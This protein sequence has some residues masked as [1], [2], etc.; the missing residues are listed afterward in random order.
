MENKTNKKSF[1]IDVFKRLMS[2]ARVY[3]GQFMGTAIAAL[4]LSGAGALR[5]Y[6]FIR[7]VDENND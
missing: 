6:L 2:Y 1:N 7:T 5:P 4:L 3:K